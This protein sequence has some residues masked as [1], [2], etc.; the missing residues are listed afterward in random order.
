MKMKKLFAVVV[1]LVVLVSVAALAAETLNV[2]GFKSLGKTMVLENGWGLKLKSSTTGTFIVG[3][4]FQNIQT[5]RK[6]RGYLPGES[7]SLKRGDEATAW[8]A[9]QA[10]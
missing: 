4:E 10:K 2:A 1:A 6:P 8:L 7:F 9:E 5:A 3:P